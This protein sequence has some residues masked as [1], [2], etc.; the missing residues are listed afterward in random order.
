MFYVTGDVH[1]DLEGLKKRKFH[2]L[3]QKDCMVICGD[4]GLIWSGSDQEAKAAR[5]LGKKRYKTLFI[6]GTHENFSLLGQYPVT[7]WCG[8]KVQV[9][10]QNL[11]HLMRGQVYEIGDRR[12]FTFGGG[13]SAEKDIRIE[14]KTWW[15]QEMPSRD[16][17]EEGVKNLEAC[18][19]KVDYIFTHEAPASL[20]R[21]FDRR[22]EEPNRLNIYLDQINKRCGFK[23][24]VIGSYHENKRL[25]GQHELVFEGVLKLD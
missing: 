7:E 25:T 2:H 17:M 21:L 13:E 10:S 23:K 20:R 22:C 9:I 3:G 8:G 5:A 4:F 6:D 12:I 11:I 14:Q 1:A 15:E 24:W 19:W 16:E 18:G